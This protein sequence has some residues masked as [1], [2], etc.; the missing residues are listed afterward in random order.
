MKNVL[1]ILIITIL[2]ICSCKKDKADPTYFGN[3]SLTLNGK[4]WYSSK[5]RCVAIKNH[6]CNPDFLGLNFDLFNGEG[7]L[8]ETFVFSHIFKEL[9]TYYLSP[10]NFG[11]LSCKDSLPSC[12]YYTIGADGDVI[13]D[14]YNTLPNSGGFIQINKYNN[15]TKE[16]EGVFSLDLLIY[17]R[18]NPNA[19]DT[20][21]VRSGKF[22]TKILN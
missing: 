12:N 8:R 15:E 20:L 3:A 14:V 9:K 22:Y 19:P 5:V 11:D 18:Y 13:L 6:P 10:T 2:V 7:F 1:K 17:T 16:L 4:S 21:R